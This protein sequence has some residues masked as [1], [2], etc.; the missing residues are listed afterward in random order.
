MKSEEILRNNELQFKQEV[1]FAVHLNNY[2]VCIKLTNQSDPEA[3]GKYL[4]SILPDNFDKKIY[5]EIPMIECSKMGASY[6]GEITED[7][8]VGEDQWT[9][10]HKFHKATGYDPRMQVNT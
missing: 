7:E 2:N 1:D 5:V 4:V 8:E 9:I 3:V 10:Y 6:D